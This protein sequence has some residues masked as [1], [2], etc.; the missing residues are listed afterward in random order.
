M[1]KSFSI[2]AMT[3]ANKRFKTSEA[4]D[5][6]T[7]VLHQLNS[8]QNKQKFENLRS[9]FDPNR[10]SYAVTIIVYY[11]ET[12][13]YTK[14]GLISAHTQDVSNYEKP[15]IDLVFLPKYFAQDPPYGCQNLNCDD[16]YITRMF[17]SKRPGTENKLIVRLKIINR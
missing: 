2:N 8:K 3:G 5:W 4:R 1:S 10:H 9:H 6:E 7:T 11:P 14:K 12:D 13:F 16:K 17:S 15:L